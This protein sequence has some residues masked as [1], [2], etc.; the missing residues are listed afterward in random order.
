LPLK[1]PFETAKDRKTHSNTVI[2]Q[3]TLDS[4]QIGLGEATPVGYVT[5]ES[6]ESAI[7]AIEQSRKVII[8]AD[9][10][11]WLSLSLEMESV[12]PQAHCARAALEM[13]MLDAAAKAA[14]MPVYQYLGGRKL[15]IVTDITI[16]I[17]TPAH[18]A[19]L[20][21]SARQNGITRLKMKANGTPEDLPRALAIAEAVPDADLKIDA[22]QA[23]SPKS[24][25][26]FVKSMDKAGLR[27]SLL[28]QPVAKEDID[29]LKYVSDNVSV[30]V[31]ADESVV[32]P[33]DAQRLVDAQ[34]VSGVNVKLMKSG[35]RGALEIVEICRNAGIGLM[36]GCMLES[37]I[38]ISAALHLAC[39]TGAFDHFDLDA[40]MLIADQPVTGGFVRK[41]GEL[42][43]SDQPGLGCRFV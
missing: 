11:E 39:A 43:V 29:G 2:I 32:T 40:D 31:F 16:P 37:K 17:S 36:L 1:E 20:A 28:E 26:A 21:K 10:A 41:G 8:G 34:T 4:G 15:S 14:D 3:I 27:L 6:I 42:E 22:N 5:G 38:G 19:E 18:A 12:L 9:P 13:A 7:A 35:I 24:A 30:P 23:F 25:V 33:T